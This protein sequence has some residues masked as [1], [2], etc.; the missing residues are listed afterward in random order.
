MNF[1]FDSDLAAAAGV[2]LD[3][4]ARRKER[5]EMDR[6]LQK[7]SEAMIAEEG[8]LN[9]AQAALV[10]DVSV[11]R[12]GDLVRLGK[13]TRFDF[14]SRTYVS[15]KEVR[16]RREMDLKAGRPPRNVVQQVVMGVK[17]AVKHDKL[18]M[19]LGGFA[20]PYEKAKAKRRK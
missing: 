7:M 5:A 8:L 16:A 17:A 19:K 2:E 1:T 11:K 13:L 12:V 10:L 20:G 18:Q 6:E 14:L 4:E 3:K 15:M 9:H